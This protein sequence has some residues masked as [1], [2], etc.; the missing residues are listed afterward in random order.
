MADVFR[1]MIVTAHM[2]PLARALAA[3]LSPRGAGMFTVALSATGEAPA[4]HY[5]SA[6]LI[7]E[8]FAG[9][10]GYSDKLHAACVAAGASVSLAQCQELVAT[11]DVTDAP[12][13]EA[14]ER[15][16]LRLVSIDP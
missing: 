15:L 7:D 14:M 13:F 6:G 11:S 8:E 12:P 9:L 3:G 2:A 10:L 4:T 5:G 16:G 1:T